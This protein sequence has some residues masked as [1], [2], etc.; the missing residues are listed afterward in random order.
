MESQQPVK[1]HP[2]RDWLAAH[3]TVDVGVIATFLVGYHFLVVKWN[4]QT[5][6]LGSADPQQRVAVYAATAGIA[7][8]LAGFSGTAI[9]QYSSAT[10]WLIDS[11]RKNHGRDIRKNWLTILRWLMLAAL[12]CVAAMVVDTESS[13]MYSDYLFIVAIAVMGLKFAR[14]STVF[15]LVLGAIDS[16][17]TYQETGT[18]PYRLKSKAESRD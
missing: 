10:G 4:P 14:L 15:R 12:L 11:V 2:V 5:N 1:G 13:P 17:A 9:A 8:L 16:Q 7:S 18:P 3:P 6:V